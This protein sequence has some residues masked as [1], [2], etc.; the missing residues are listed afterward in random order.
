MKAL[1]L[2]LI[3]LA[4]TAAALGTWFYLSFSHSPR[5]E[6]NHPAEF[7]QFIAAKEAR[8]APATGFDDGSGKTVSLA[9]FRGRLVL[10]NLWATWCVP[11]VKEMPSLER[12]QARLGGQGLEI[13]AVSED[14]GG[15]PLVAPFRDKIGL[16][17][18]KTYLDPKGELGLA[19]GIRGLPTSILLDRDGHELGRVEGEAQWDGA[20]E[21][22]L[23]Q[24]YLGSQ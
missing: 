5:E 24:R 11:C 23:F 8:P 20:P 21:T 9:D 1:R 2:A 14:R 19:F 17:A 3:P 7:G 4:L 15:Q 6:N 12:V 18:L 22:A 13:V 10:V 16:K